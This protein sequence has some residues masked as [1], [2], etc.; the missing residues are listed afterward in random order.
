MSRHFCV[1]GLFFVALALCACSG[2]AKT[3]KSVTHVTQHPVT[4]VT[5]NQFVLGN[6]TPGNHLSSVSAGQ[7]AAF[8]LRS[9]RNGTVTAIDLYV[10]ARSRAKTLAVGLYSAGAGQPGHSIVSTPQ[11][12]LRRGHWN[13]LTVKSQPR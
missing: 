11:M 3:G 10:D 1:F 7:A 9:P 13:V 4:H 8:A 2:S 12:P 6:P 5:Q